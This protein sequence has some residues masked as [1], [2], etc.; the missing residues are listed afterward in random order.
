MFTDCKSVIKTMFLS[1][2]LLARRM[3][4]SLTASSTFTVWSELTLVSVL[5]FDKS[6]VLL[7]KEE[8]LSK[9]DQGP[10]LC[11]FRER[12]DLWVL[13]SLCSKRPWLFRKNRGTG[14]EQAA[15]QPRGVRSVSRR[16]GLSCLLLAWRKPRQHK[17]PVSNRGAEKQRK[18]SYRL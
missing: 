7:A 4:A 14:P 18:R 5:S 16:A 12:G 8:I 1:S 15:G 11:G 17:P 9:A 2:R 3:I 6:N 13:Y 10:G